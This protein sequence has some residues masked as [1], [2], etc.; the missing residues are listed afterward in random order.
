LRELD[1]VSRA[2]VALVFD[3]ETQWIG[4]IQ[5]H[6][7]GFDYQTLAFEYYRTLREMALDVDIV[8]ADA[9]LSGYALVVVPSLAVLPRGFVEKISSSDAQWVIGP[10]TGSKTIDFAIPADLPPGALQAVLPFKV[11]EVDSLRPSLRPSTTF[12]GVQGIAL[13]WREHI[14]TSDGLDVLARFDDA[15]PAIVAAN[16]VRYAT[17]WFDAPLHR[18]LLER[19]ARDAGLDITA[20]PPGVRVRR[21]GDVTFAF[22]FG[23]HS[24]DAPA[25]ADAHFVLGERKLATAD[26]CAW[27]AQ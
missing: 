2:P 10:R 26:V 21:R 12:D 15:W 5:P 20:L 22:N 19:A 11:I 7:K 8:S 18:A 14:E 17:A 9:D 3:Y 25:P 24:V 13:L 4:E 16:N 1:A 6:A 23:E 27:I